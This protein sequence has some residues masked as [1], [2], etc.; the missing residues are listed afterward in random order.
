MLIF[1]IQIRTIVFLLNLFMLYLCFLPFQEPFFLN[2][3]ET[4]GLKY[5]IKQSLICFIFPYRHKYLNIGTL[6]STINLIIKNCLKFFCVFILPCSPTY[7]TLDRSFDVQI[8]FSEFLY[9]ENSLYSILQSQYCW[10]ENPSLVFSFVG[11]LRYLIQFSVGKSDYELILK[12][13]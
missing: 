2:P 1:T 13:H 6:N 9:F 3:L 10:I 11:Y 5:L 8:L 12:R 7:A 4:V